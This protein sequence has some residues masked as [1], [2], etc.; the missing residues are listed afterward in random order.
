MRGQTLQAVLLSV[1]VCADRLFKP[2][3]SPLPGVRP[4]QGG[5]LRASGRDDRADRERG[6]R[7]DDRHRDAR[8]GHHP[9]YDPRQRQRLR[10]ASRALPG[11]RLPAV[12]TPARKWNRVS[13]SIYDNRHDADSFLRKLTAVE[14]I[15]SHY[16]KSLLKLC[17]RY[18]EALRLTKARF[19][20]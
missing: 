18:Y 20:D 3:S 13:Q 7:V 12:D 8:N 4:H 16:S 5:V 10:G 15:F 9:T 19:S 11:R 17:G 2:Y 6:G 1:A 14:A